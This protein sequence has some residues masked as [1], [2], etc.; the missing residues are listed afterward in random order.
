[1]EVPQS[2]NASIPGSEKINGLT[3]E[4]VGERRLHKQL[5]PTL[6]LKRKRDDKD[7][8]KNNKERVMWKKTT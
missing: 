5:R 3:G 2:Q 6:F 7:K 4:G 1:M 8:K